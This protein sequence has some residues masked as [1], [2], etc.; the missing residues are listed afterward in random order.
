[1]RTVEVIP[2]IKVTAWAQKEGDGS[3]FSGR[4]V[5]GREPT[6]TDGSLGIIHEGPMPAG[7]TPNQAIELAVL[8][9]RRMIKLG[10]LESIYG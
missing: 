10:V 1:M 7:S 9:V 4:A 8:D 3:L 5:W 6:V 2:G